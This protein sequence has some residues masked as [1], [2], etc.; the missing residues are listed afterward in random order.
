MTKAH[1][2]T[3]ERF[4]IGDKPLNR[5]VRAALAELDR[6]PHCEGTGRLWRFVDADVCTPLLAR[7]YE[8]S[9]VGAFWVA[10]IRDGAMLRAE[11][12]WLNLALIAS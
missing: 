1:R 4:A 9:G 11:I 8:I 7:L 6:C 2:R 10:E 5:A 12:A 3:L